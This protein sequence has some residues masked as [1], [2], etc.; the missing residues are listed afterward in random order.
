MQIQARH[1]REVLPADHPETSPEQMSNLQR[2]EATTVPIP[3]VAAT[4]TTEAVRHL[5][6][7]DTI[8][9]VTTV[10]VPQ[11]RREEEVPHTG[12]GRMF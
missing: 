4:S 11:D 8:E 2:H 10:Q 9:A 5:M 1:P 6:A 7:A 12:E 3:G